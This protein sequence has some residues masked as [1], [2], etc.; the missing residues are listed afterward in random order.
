MKKTAAVRRALISNQ[1]KIINVKTE[2]CALNQISAKH[3]VLAKFSIVLQLIQ[4][5]KFATR[6]VH[7][8]ST[9]V[10]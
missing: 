9:T 10:F 5:E 2:V 8:T 1:P 3:G 6:F 4:M 7:H